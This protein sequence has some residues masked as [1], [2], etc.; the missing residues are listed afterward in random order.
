MSTGSPF[1]ALPAVLAEI[2]EVAAERLG[3]AEAGL[4]AALAVARAKGGQR[5]Y[6]LPELSANSWLVEAVGAE[7]AAALVA[8]YATGAGD[9]IEIPMGPAAG[10][11][12]QARS[13]R[14]VIEAGL[15]AKLPIDE[16]A[17]EAN[18]TR[19]WVFWVQAQLQRKPDSRQLS[20]FPDQAA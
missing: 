17:R 19:R 15:A 12:A 5:V 20:L 6:I 11:N 14:A 16:I 7:A 13:R 3:S 18:C 8:F 4:K 10:F 9:R 2:A 1:D